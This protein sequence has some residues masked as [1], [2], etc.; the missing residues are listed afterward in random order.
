MLS[1]IPTY[2][3]RR[4]K[5][6]RPD[7]ADKRVS[8]E[9]FTA[10]A[11]TLASVGFENEVAANGQ[12]LIWLEPPVVDR[13]RALRGPDES[14]SDVILRLAAEGGR[15]LAWSGRELQRRDPA[16]GGR[17]DM[18]DEQRQ[19]GHWKNEKS[20]RLELAMIA[21]FEGDDLLG[22]ELQLIR[23]YLT[24]DWLPVWQGRRPRR[25]RA[26]PDR[27][28]SPRRPLSGLGPQGGISRARS[29]TPAAAVTGGCGRFCTRPPTSASTPSPS[30]RARRWR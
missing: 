25:L 12:R 8:E 4:L 26:P 6:D 13:L 5:R 17:G 7:L 27:G 30:R 28:Q 2:A 29:T 23:L 11:S 20:R 19:P 10:I 21:L 16:A 22:G 9:A 24:A 18:C 14:Y 1:A 15:R 3:L